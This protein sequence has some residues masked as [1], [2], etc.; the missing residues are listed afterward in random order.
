MARQEKFKQQKIFSA[1]W[2]PFSW[3]TLCIACLH[4]ASPKPP[5]EQEYLLNHKEQHSLSINKTTPSKITFLLDLVR[6]HMT[7]RIA[8]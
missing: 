2:P 6:C 3:P 1:R 5:Q 8:A 7:Y 4:Y